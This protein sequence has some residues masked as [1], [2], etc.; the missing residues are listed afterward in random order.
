MHT[1][2][3]TV[4][5]AGLIGKAIVHDLCHD[6]AVTVVDH[7]PAALE[8]LTHHPCGHAAV[9]AFATGAL[10]SV[11]AHA[12]LVVMAMPG[13]IGY[14]LLE[15]LVRMGKRVVDISFTEEDPTELH[16]LAVEHGAVVIPDAGLCPGLSNLVAGYAAAQRFSRLDK[17]V[18]YVG[19]LPREP[20]GPWF[21]RNPFAA[22]S[23][24]DEYTRPCRFRINGEDVVREP[25]LDAEEFEFPGVGPLIA[26]NTD[27]IRTLLRTLP[28]VP[29]LV[30]KTLRHRE[31]YQFIRALQQAGFLTAARAEAFT[32]VAS[33]GWKFERGEEDITVMR[34]LFEGLGLDGA[35]LRLH[36]DLLDRYDHEARLLSM[37]RTTGYTAAAVARLLL[38]GGFSEPGVHAP[39]KFGMN[40]GCYQAIMAHLKTRGIGFTSDSA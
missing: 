38:A 37:A 28:Q 5:G 30:E 8:A 1:P 13:A 7:S 12:D 27:G 9:D 6:F 36:F 17:Y 2:H 22:A 34:L 40:A 26:F 4:L 19:G 33:P 29:T 20:K 25:L 10:E 39:E 31:H 23:V 21:Y 24:V 14:K 3:V 11:A 35:P 15:R 18:C 16:E 32:E